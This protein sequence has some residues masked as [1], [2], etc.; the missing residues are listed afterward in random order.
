MLAADNTPDFRTIS[1]FR[2]D[3][4]EALSGLFLLVKLRHVALHSTKVRANASR[5]KA[6]SYGR[7][8]EKEAQLAAEVDEEEDRRCGRDKRCDELPGELAYREGRL[9]RIRGAK[10]ALEAEEQAAAGQAEVR[11]DTRAP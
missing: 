7:I 8:K 11:E 3:H 10:A 4:L 5:H 1:D 9:R 2:K 6:M